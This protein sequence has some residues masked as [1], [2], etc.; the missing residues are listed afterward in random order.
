[1][2]KFIARSAAGALALSVLG[3]S[4]A[5]AGILEVSASKGSLSAFARF[6]ADGSRLKVTLDNT[7]MMDANQPADMLSA[8]FFDITGD[9]LSLIRGSASLGATDDVVMSS[10]QPIGRDVGG[11]WAYN[12]GLRGAPGAASYGISSAALGLFGP[13]HL[14]P[15]ANLDATASPSMI[16]YAITSRMD[17]GE[18][19]IYGAKVP[20]IRSCVV[21]TLDGLPAGFDPAERIVNISFQYGAELR[22]PNLPVAAVVPGPGAAG[23]LALGGFVLGVR[24][25][26]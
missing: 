20:L 14:F 25:R 10:A 21:F 9:A 22:N 5:H 16:S 6:E 26:R 19:N 8:V 1:M 3:A 23:L 4:H 17:S 13:S 12:R 2:K 18:N 11:E 15:G 7:S 24:R